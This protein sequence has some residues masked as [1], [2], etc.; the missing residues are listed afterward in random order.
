ML[1]KISLTV[2]MLASYSSAMQLT[3]EQDNCAS[4]ID[5]PYPNA[6]KTVTISPP[7]ESCCTTG[8]TSSCTNPI[9]D[10]VDNAV[11]FQIIQLEPGTYCNPKWSA[12]HTKY[13]DMMH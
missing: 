7:D 10:A 4:T 3:T 2:A 5:L 11:N 12:T 13:G 8:W 1:S 9:Q 6:W